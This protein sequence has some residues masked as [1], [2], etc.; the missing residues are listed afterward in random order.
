M[1]T[2]NQ[3]SLF[4][5]RNGGAKVHWREHPEAGG[6]RGDSGGGDTYSHD[7]PEGAGGDS[8][9][10]EDGG[11]HNGC[12]MMRVRSSW[13]RTASPC[14]RGRGSRAFPAGKAP[15]PIS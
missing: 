14:L 5:G 10:P 7:D 2:I 3:I 1:N 11:N 8:F 6:H 13:Q 4:A 12:L 15:R 9:P